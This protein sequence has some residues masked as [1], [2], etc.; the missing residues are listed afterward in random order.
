MYTIKHASELTGV[1]VAT[2]RAWERRYGVVSPR[3]TDAGYRLYDEE[4]LGRIRSMQELVA[5]GWSPQQA[6]AEVRSRPAPTG[7][8][9]GGALRGEQ[10]SAPE[11]PAPR[12]GPVDG[13]GGDASALAGAAASLDADELAQVLDDHFGQGRFETVVDGWLMPSLDELGRGWAD[14]TVSVAAEHVASSAVTRRLATAFEASGH[15]RNGARVVV[16]LPPGARHEIGALAFAVAARRAGLA[17]TYLGPDLPVGSW[18]EAVGLHRAAAA[19][20]AVPCAED[21]PSAGEVA[22]AVALAHPAARVLVGGS[23][24]DAVPPPAVPLGH[25]IGPAAQLLADR[26]A[27]G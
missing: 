20:V 4:S 10:P 2:L 5:A 12:P 1:A 23:H 9:P 6:A 19:V 14:G 13:I 25:R 24:Q 3:R 11:G 21:V 27:P 18:V 7:G 15:N 26:L 17:V 16:G 22:R 8:G